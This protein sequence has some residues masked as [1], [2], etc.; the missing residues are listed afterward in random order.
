MA[1]AQGKSALSTDDW[2][3]I[4]ILEWSKYE[5][6]RRRENASN[7]KFLSGAFER[8]SQFP[9]VILTIIFRHLDYQD[10]LCAADSVARHLLFNVMPSLA[11]NHMA[12]TL[13]KLSKVHDSFNRFALAFSVFDADA[14]ARVFRHLPAEEIIRLFHISRAR[15]KRAIL[16]P[17]PI[18]TDRGPYILRRFNIAK[19]VLKGSP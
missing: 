2:R 6:D 5:E 7:V 19:S 14:Q 9:E 10:N 16:N 4:A 17:V 15:I 11:P 8:H 18:G 12:T 3:Y 1:L 13:E